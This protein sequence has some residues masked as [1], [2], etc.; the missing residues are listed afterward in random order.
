MAHGLVAT[1]DY[2][3]HKERAIEAPRIRSDAD[4]GLKLLN[5]AQ[6]INTSCPH[7]HTIIVYVIAKYLLLKKI[8]V[9]MDSVGK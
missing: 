9:G 6:R 4:P 3:N 8:S 1:S 2:P 5:A 7:G